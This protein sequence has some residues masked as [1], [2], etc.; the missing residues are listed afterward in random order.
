[1]NRLSKGHLK[2]YAALREAVDDAAHRAQEDVGEYNEAL[3]NLAL[4]T[5]SLE[6][7]NDAVL[8]FNAWM[9]EVRGEMDCYF[10]DR[11]E[12]W[13]RGEAGELYLEWMTLFEELMDEVDTF[14]D[15][16]EP[17][18]EPLAEVPELP[19]SPDEA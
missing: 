18:E 12:Q 3:A 1:M 2:T 10:D 13:Q 14:P 17:L 15:D 11:S 4:P 7:L 8:N 19:S 16:P 6:A 5:E 9:E